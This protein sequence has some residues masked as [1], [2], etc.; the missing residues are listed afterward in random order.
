MAYQS[1]L[2]HL[3][4]RKNE[5]RD[6]SIAILKAWAGTNT[7]FKGENAPLEAAWCMGAMSRAAELLKHTP[8]SMQQWKSIEPLFL[9]WLNNIM[10]P[11]LKEPSI[12]RW[13]IV[14]NWHYSIIDARMQIA[15]LRDDYDE[16][17][18]C[19]KTY[20]SSLEKTLCKQ[21]ECHTCETKRD[22]THF[23]FLLGGLCQIPE[24]AWHQG[25]NLYIPRMCKV[26]EYHAAIMLKEVPDGLTRED[27]KTPYGYWYEPV[28][29][30][31]YNHY[32]KRC[33]QPMPKTE[34]WLQTFRPERVCF[35]WGA[36]TLTHF[37]RVT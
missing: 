8:S 27:I 18:W 20:Q 11:V 16:L 22:V 31:P 7:V 2:L 10:M 29:E 1:A 35:Q 19:I 6:L 3:A 24:M 17:Q 36:G 15:I 12:W 21:H 13:N 32:T 5:Y 33:K 25:I 9:S 37:D 28:W 14:N 26:V 30:I 4:T 34:K 23:Q